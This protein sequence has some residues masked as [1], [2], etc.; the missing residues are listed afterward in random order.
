MDLKSKIRVIEDFPKKGISFKDITTL[1]KDGAAFREI[2]DTI[3]EDLREKNI[4]IVVGPEA[5]GFMIAAAVAYALG[6]AFVPVRKPGKLMICWLQ[7]ER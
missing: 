6:A 7:E 3:A 2:V 4:D 1:L 5:R